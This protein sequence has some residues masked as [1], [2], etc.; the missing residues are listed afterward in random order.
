MA[1][2]LQIFLHSRNQQQDDTTKA[3]IIY[4]NYPFTPQ[5]DDPNNKEIPVK[6]DK[7]SK[8]P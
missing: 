2:N 4:S 3:T 1:L 8:P 6:S 5:K 7:K